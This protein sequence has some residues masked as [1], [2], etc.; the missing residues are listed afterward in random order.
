M[1]GATTVLRKPCTRLLLQYCILW[2]LSG[3]LCCAQNLPLD[4]Q[5]R[6]RAAQELA[7]KMSAAANARPP[8]I[9][10]SGGITFVPGATPA[11]SAPGAGEINP[12]VAA[13]QAVANRFSV[14]V[15]RALRQGCI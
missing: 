4:V 11:A 12:L 9:I 6:V 5:E 1:L 8:S 10:T 13:A 3:L 7:A 2:L 15:R 14:A